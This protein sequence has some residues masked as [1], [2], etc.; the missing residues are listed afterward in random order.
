METH[1]APTRRQFLTAIGAAAAAAGLAGCSA[2]HAPAETN[3]SDTGIDEG[4]SWVGTDPT[5]GEDEIIESLSCD[6]LIIGA[7][8]AGMV[9]AATA[10]AEGLDFIICEKG[11]AVAASRHW[12]GA[13]NSAFAKQAGCEVDEERLLN[14]M[15]RYASGRCDQAVWRTW[16][17]ESGETVEFVADA[18]AESGMQLF[19]DGEGNENPAGGTSFYTPA[20][21]HMVFDDGAPGPIPVAG[22][23]SNVQR[24]QAL[25]NYITSRGYAVR[26]GHEMVSLVQDGSRVTGAY[27][28]T[29]DGYVLV[30]AAKGV[31]L[32]TGGYAANTDMVRALNPT[33][34]NG[35]TTSSFEPGNT[36]DGIRAALRIGALMDENPASMVFDRGI[37]APGVDAGWDESGEYPLSCMAQDAMMPGSQPFLKVNRFGKRFFNESAPYDWAINASSKQPGG[38]FCSIMDA[39]AGADAARFS[40]LGCSKVGT[41]LLN[42]GPVEAVF[43]PLVEDGRLIVADTLE[44]LADGLG[45]PKETFLATVERYNDLYDKQKDEDFGKE[46]Y[47]LS[48]IR[49]APFYGFW[50]GGELFTTLDGLQINADMQV[51]GQNREPIEGLYAAGDCSGSLFCDNYPEYIVGCAC[52]RTITFGRHAVRHMAGLV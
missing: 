7:G 32:A 19:F 16:I 29:G 42:Q 38:V 34:P 15:S 44:E 35:V 31:L 23:M 9:A 8:Q 26:Y 1:F 48:A 47:R 12:M 40:T 46:A 28:Q 25:E 2:N 30:N 41:F 3:L 21:Q 27:F 33:M 5:I 39:N 36:G 17:K 50:I 20:V 49:Q 22:D 45:L 43:G 14:E 11:G 52:G 24:N 10:A 13:V 18:V 37:V 51:L 6:I 4:I